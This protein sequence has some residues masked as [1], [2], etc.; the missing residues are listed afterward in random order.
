MIELLCQ[1]RLKNTS[2]RYWASSSLFSAT[3]LQEK[4]SR[5]TSTLF[6]KKCKWRWR[7]AKG[8]N[9]IRLG[10]CHHLSPASLPLPSYKTAHRALLLLGRERRKQKDQG[11]TSLWS[12]CEEKDQVAV[13]NINGRSSCY[14]VWGSLPHTSS[15]LH[16]NLSH[17]DKKADMNRTEQGCSAAEGDGLSL[18]GA[19]SHRFTRCKDKAFLVTTAIC[20]DRVTTRFLPADRHLPAGAAARQGQCGAQGRTRLQQQFRVHRVTSL[21]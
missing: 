12:A 17:F 11:K 18:W 9:Q 7:K 6:L 13:S 20:Q 2:Q 19:G 1:E 3:D 16:Q 14:R 4:S 21:L 8:W 10:V 5:K 15:R